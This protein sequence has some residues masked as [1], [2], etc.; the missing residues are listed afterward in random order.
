M[1]HWLQ[2]DCMSTLNI[3]ENDQQDASHWSFSRIC[4]MM[5]GSEYVNSTLK[6][7]Y[8][9]NP[10]PANVE[11]MVT[12]NNSSKWQM[13]LNLAFKGL[14]TTVIITLYYIIFYCFWCWCIVSLSC[15]VQIV[16]EFEMSNVTHCDYVNWINI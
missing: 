12:A 13:G 3:R 4:I 11:N 2:V 1:S 16:T 7:P 14:I 10:Y 6:L 5:H 9:F 15:D 8:C